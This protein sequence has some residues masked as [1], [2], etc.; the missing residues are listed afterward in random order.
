MVAVVCQ[1][2]AFII[3]VRG[4]LVV[5]SAAIGL[6]HLAYRLVVTVACVLVVDCKADY[7]VIDTDRFVEVG[8]SQVMPVLPAGEY[9]LELALS[10]VPE[11]SENVRSAHQ[12]YEVIVID[13]INCIILCIGEIELISHL[14]GEEQGLCLCSCVAHCIR[15][16]KT[17]GDCCNCNNKLFHG[18]S[19]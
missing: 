19:F 8:G 15:L 17:Y 3:V 10:T 14:I 16:Y 9:P 5:V 18:V 6:V 2:V 7:V 13:L 4:S 1:A 11:N 12:T